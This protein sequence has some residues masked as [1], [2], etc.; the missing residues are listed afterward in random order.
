MAVASRKGKQDLTVV[1]MSQSGLRDD[2]RG[3]CTYVVANV[4]KKGR[5][6]KE[7]TSD[8]KSRLAA[9]NDAGYRKSEFLKLTGITRST[10]YIFLKR[11]DHRGDIE[12]MRRTGRPT[13][14][15][16]RDMRK[17][18]R[19][20]K[21]I[22]VDLYLKLLIFNESIVRPFSKRTVERKLHSDGFHKRSVKKKKSY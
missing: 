10:V 19:C 17:L 22:A 21:N 1:S 13:S 15:H 6:G 20:V 5:M 12:N 16:G 4:N 9:L 2:I 18:S 11:Y 14:F 7:L 8:Q 3:V